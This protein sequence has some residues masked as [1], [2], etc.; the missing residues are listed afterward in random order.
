MGMKG[1][2]SLPGWESSAGENSRTGKLTDSQVRAIRVQIGK[3]EEIALQYGISAGY[4]IA[5]KRGSKRTDV[6]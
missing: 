1:S 3:P 2:M 5:I 6:K 4:V